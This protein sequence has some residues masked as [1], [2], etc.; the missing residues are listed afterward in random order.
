MEGKGRRERQVAI[1]LSKVLSRQRGKEIG[2]YFGIKGP[3]VSGVINGIE[4]RLEE[5]IKLR[6]EIEY[7]R[8]KL[9]TEF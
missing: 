7:L 4:G 6:R 3:A 9:I 1:Y 5:E 8:D 2:R